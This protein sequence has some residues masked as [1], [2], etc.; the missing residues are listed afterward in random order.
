MPLGN[1]YPGQI[2]SIASAL[3]L[4]GERWTLLIVR[5]VMLGVHRFDEIQA[6]LG[7]ARNVL[8]A[9]LER[10]VDGGVLERRRYQEHPPRDDYHLTPAGRDLWPALF[11]LM[12]WG[13]AHAPR[14]D[15]PPV[16]VSHRGCGGDVDDHRVCQRCGAQLELRDIVARA[17]ASASARHPLRRRAAA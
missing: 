11:A 12:R 6:D 14:P 17:G 1:A 15:G 16:L 2:C 13:D 9:R 8:Q 10:L 5:E 4:V 7:I 3:E